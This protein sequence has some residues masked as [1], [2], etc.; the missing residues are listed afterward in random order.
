MF[1]VSA[2]SLSLSF[3]LWLFILTTLIT[4]VIVN[5]ASM[6]IHR[7]KPELS[8]AE[9]LLMMLRPDQQFSLT[10]KQKCWIPR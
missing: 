2:F 9:N 5:D 7:P 10:S 3:L 8:T 1:C 4:R 6:Y